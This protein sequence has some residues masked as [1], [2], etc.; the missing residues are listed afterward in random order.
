MTHCDRILEYMRQHGSITQK[1]ATDNFGCTRLSG[2][3]YDL[4]KRGVKIRKTF[5]AGTNRFGEPEHHAR[6]T[7]E[8]EQLA[9]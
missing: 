6:Y 7:I 4:K 5:E 3:I 8:A 2:R 9:V 1:E